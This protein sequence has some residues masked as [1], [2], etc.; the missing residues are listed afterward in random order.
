MPLTAAFNLAFTI[1]QIL[2]DI[3]R[4]R[5]STTEA[6]FSNRQQKPAVFAAVGSPL[7]RSQHDSVG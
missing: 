2:A 3:K 1:V 5:A 6:C 7:R 4:G